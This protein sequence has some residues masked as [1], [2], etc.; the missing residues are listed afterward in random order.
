MATAKEIENIV[1]DAVR[2]KKEDDLK[3]STTEKNSSTDAAMNHRKQIDEEIIRK[4]VDYAKVLKVVI[5]VCFIIAMCLT[6]YKT[7]SYM[8][9]REKD[10]W[11]KPSILPSDYTKASEFVTA[12][13]RKTAKKGNIEDF[14]EASVPYPWRNSA[15]KIFS[16]PAVKDY[17]VKEVKF[18]MFK[19]GDEAVFHVQCVNPA[20]SGI[21]FTLLMRDGIFKIMKINAI[22]ATE[23]KK[24]G[25]RKNEK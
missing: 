24:D 1:R 15:K 5:T 2:R 9:S 23:I 25:D 3:K 10:L 18:D 4:R 16:D 7:L 22:S 11:Q 12:A 6:A 8:K 21:S 13:I 20:G 19:L 17:T 14:F